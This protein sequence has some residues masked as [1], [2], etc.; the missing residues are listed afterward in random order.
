MIGRLRGTLASVGPDRLIVDVGGVGYEVAVPTRAL[1]E[2]PALGEEVVLHTH[3]HV[4]EDALALHGFP[5]ERELATFRLLIGAPGVG[6]KVGLAILST[7]DPDAVAIAIVEEDVSTLS[8]VP[9]IGK[10]TAQKLVLELKPKFSGMEV[11][12]IGG[13][14]YTEV[15]LA[16][17][18]LGYSDG[19][20]A[21][22][23][24][25]VD[26]GAPPEEQLRSALRNLA[27]RRRA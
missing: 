14:G 6:P 17:G 10:R 11:G 16:L 22:V 18:Q 4:R 19:E 9:G 3:L 2:L 24:G 12:S 27:G 5:S 20:V 21:E 13:G 25:E 8:S 23:I 26:P 1:T 15:R 7:L